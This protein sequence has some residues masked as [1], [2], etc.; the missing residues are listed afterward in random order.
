MDAPVS[1]GGNKELM[2]LRFN[3]VFRLFAGRVWVRGSCVIRAT[4]RWRQCWCRDT[5]YVACDPRH[6]SCWRCGCP[7]GRSRGGQHAHRDP[8]QGAE[9]AALGAA[10]PVIMRVGLMI[11]RVGVMITARVAFGQVDEGGGGFSAG[12]WRAHSLS[13]TCAE[14]AVSC[15]PSP[16]QDSPGACAGLGLPKA[17]RLTPLDHRPSDVI[18]DGA[19]GGWN[20]RSSAHCASRAG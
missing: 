1:L 16:L 14:W 5:L 15:S 9:S 2:E 12:R 7:D 3:Y 20:G 10:P 18:H 11:M 19:G 8:H 17:P 4:V 13:I 6:P